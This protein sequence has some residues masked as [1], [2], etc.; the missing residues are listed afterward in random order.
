MGK[1]HFSV[2]RAVVEEEMSFSSKD[3]FDCYCLNMDLKGEPYNIVNV[4]HEP[5]GRCIVIMRKRY[6]EYPFLGEPDE[7]SIDA[8]RLEAFRRALRRK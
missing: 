5:D 8:D 1:Y 4:S 6:G 2:R 7:P 3:S